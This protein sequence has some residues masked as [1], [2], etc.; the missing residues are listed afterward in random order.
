MIRLIVEQTLYQSPIS[1]K[2]RYL[3]ATALSKRTFAASE[4]TQW[5]TSA[6]PEKRIDPND[7]KDFKVFKDLKVLKDPPKK[8]FPACFLAGGETLN[9]KYGTKM[10]PSPEREYIVDSC[11]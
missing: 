1:A 8:S 7:F 11:G 9:R 4:L 6:T 2:I 10:P 5:Q 3:C